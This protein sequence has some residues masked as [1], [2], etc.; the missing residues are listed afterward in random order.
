MKTK[1]SRIRALAEF[2]QDVY[3]PGLHIAFAA[4]WYAALDGGLHVVNG[5]AWQP[6]WYL[7][8]GSAIFFVVLLFLR[9][10]DEWKDLEYDKVHNP[11]RPLVRGVVTLPDLYWF[12]A[13]TAF[14]AVGLQLLT[15]A[16]VSTE[17][18]LGILVADLAYGLFLVGL[19]RISPS[20][21]DRM[22]LNLVVTY[23]VN[24]ALS[25]HASAAFLGR[26]GG[27]W[28]P[29]VFLLIGGFAMAFLH[30]EFARK[31]SWP[32]HAKQG[33]RLYSAALGVVPALLLAV[34]FA[35]GSIAAVVALLA[36]ATPLGFAPAAALLPVVPG[37]RKFLA[38]RGQKTI[39]KPS[40]P[41]TPFAMMFLVLFYSTLILTSLAA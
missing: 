37:V 12:L 34:G 27:A 16:G 29:R 9:I 32:Q 15:P 1:Q 6:G 28:N 30:Y 23:P 17:L 36:P 10:L 14:V 26:T 20:V 19:E 25:F 38:L 7:A 18:P 2:V 39:Q 41:L 3:A 11:D 24:V 13:F 5:L 21:R 31:I 35:L 4:A 33:K 8:T 22:M 40:A